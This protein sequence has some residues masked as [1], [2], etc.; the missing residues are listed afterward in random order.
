MF[1]WTAFIM[2]L[3]GS[4][5]CAGMCGPIA[6]SLPYR[7]GLQ[8]KEETFFKILTYN[9][10]RVL[11]YALMGLVFG[12]I[13]KSFFTMGIQKYLLIV[14]AIVLI[15][16]ALFSIDIESLSLKISFINKFNTFIKKKLSFSM[17][18]TTIVSF[19]YIGILNGFLPCGLVYMAIVASISVGSVFQAV[20]YMI[21]FG[22]GTMPMMMALGFGGNL[23]S[24]RFRTFLR[25]MYPVFMIAFAVLF[26][27]RAFKIGLLPDDFDF[28]MH[29]LESSSPD[30]PPCC[31]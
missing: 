18:N 27:L 21:L 13:G 11:T 20:F 24:M 22:F 9:L 2:G 17:K 3:V 23:V 28:W 5:H 31:K 14:L 29:A 19:F 1:L 26:L 15:L 16:I 10:G 30:N 4:L 25:R 12:F 7:V 8:P 6:I